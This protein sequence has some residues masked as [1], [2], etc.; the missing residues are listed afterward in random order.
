MNRFQF[1]EDHKDAYGVKRLCEVIEIA[2]SSFYAWL[3]AAP[4]RAA[5]QSALPRRERNRPDDWRCPR[6]A[7]AR[8]GRTRTHHLRLMQRRS[9]LSHIG[10]TFGNVG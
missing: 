1:V 8:L 4:G 3:S 5:R 6:P 7:T 10:S 2:R 9:K